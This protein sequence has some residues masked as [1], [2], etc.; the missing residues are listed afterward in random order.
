MSKAPVSVSS[1]K[2]WHWINAGL[3]YVLSKLLGSAVGALQLGFTGVLTLA[4]TIALILRRGIDLSRAAGEW[5]MRLMKKI[6]QALGMK[7]AKPVKS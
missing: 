4:D 2:I 7:V 1:P 3:T 6:M 5:V